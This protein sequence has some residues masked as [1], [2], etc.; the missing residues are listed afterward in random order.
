MPYSQEEVKESIEHRDALLDIRAI[1][2]TSSG[3]RFFKY[4]FKSFD[5]C[6]L[7]EQGL[8]GEILHERI[9]VLRA[10]H[11]MF[12]LISEAN[13]QVAANI[14]AEVEKERYARLYPPPKAPR[15]E[16]GS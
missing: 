5:V 2:A 12:K 1:L 10:G 3:T 4:L 9:G 7:P 14:L 8:E 15:R 11:A 16:E 13:H 6:E